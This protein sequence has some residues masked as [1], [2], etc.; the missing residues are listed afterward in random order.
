MSTAMINKTVTI[1]V[2]FVIL[3]VV[4]PI[5]LL[6]WANLTSAFSGTVLASLFGATI[7]QILIGGAVIYLAYRM[8]QFKKS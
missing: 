2:M 6:S 4:T 7:G 3:G 1:V 5:L 8:I